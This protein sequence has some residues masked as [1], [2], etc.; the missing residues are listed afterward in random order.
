MLKKHENT[1]SLFQKTLDSVIVLLCWFAAFAFRFY[2]MAETQTSGMD[3]LLIN[4]SPFLVILTLYFFH[5]NGLYRSYRFSK[6]IK[7]ILAVFKGN[8]QAF[9]GIIIL[10]YFFAPDRI[11]RIMLASYFVISQISL[12]LG[13]LLVR[14][15]LRRLRAKGLNLRHV[16]LIGNGP[17]M[18]EYLKT[19]RKFK[20]SGINILG[21]IDG[22]NIAQK[23]Q[24]KELKMEVLEAKEKLSPDL[25]T[26][27]Y[28]GKESHKID[29]VL[30]Y[31]H[32]DVIPIQILPNLGFSFIGHKIEDFDGIP[33]LNVN[34][35]IFNGIEL[36][37]KRFFDFS[38]SLIGLI[39]ISPLLFVLAILVKLTSK[40][41][42]FYGQNRLGLD[43]HH[44]KMWKFRSMKVAALNATDAPTWTVENDP[45]RT[46]YGTFLRKTSLDE[47]P[48]LWNVLIGDMS[49]VGPRPEQP[50]WVDKFRHEIPAYMLRHKVRCGITGWA[51]INGW[52]GDTS[53][54]KRIECDIFYIKHWSFWFDI[55]ILFLTFWKGFINK[56]AY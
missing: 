46:K 33:L 29:E 25:I 50:H 22:P 41:P 38:A 51:Q 24:L 34:Q 1:F 56:N 28:S 30:K 55:K 48:Q 40:G 18:E 44:F 8:T 36:G 19:I 35:P 17:Q 31:S 42:I 9:L 5:Q 54:H 3:S 39:I 37:L 11:S 32:N 6:R 7:E 15:V 27:S 23:F 4:L 21:I 45:R 16:L 13:R 12:I 10:L 26:I 53:L 20:D 47:L 2:F 14:N 52:R 49:L 43:G